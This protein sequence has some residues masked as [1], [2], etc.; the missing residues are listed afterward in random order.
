MLG[1]RWPICAGSTARSDLLS[2]RVDDP[3]DRFGK[4]KE[5]DDEIPV[6][7]PALGDG[8]IFCTP[9]PFG[10]SLQGRVASVGVDCV[11][12]RFERLRDGLAILAENPL[13][14]GSD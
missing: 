5:R 3:S 8:G 14:G 7:A 11:I 10:E 6:A 12:D 4:R 2:C 9:C 1:S 13:N